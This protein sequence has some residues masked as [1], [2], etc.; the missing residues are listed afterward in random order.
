[1]V[2]L[3]LL[4]A[5]PALGVLEKL[6]SASAVLAPNKSLISWGGDLQQFVPLYEFFSLP[7]EAFSGLF[8]VAMLVL[9][10]LALRRLERPLAWD[11]ARC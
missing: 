8:I 3:G 6:L 7:T 5:I 2:P 9:A 11:S 1:M 4:L 10:W